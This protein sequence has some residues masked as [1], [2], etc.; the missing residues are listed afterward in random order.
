M[1]DLVD[2]GGGEARDIVTIADA[3]PV[4]P[5][6]RHHGELQLHIGVEGII[7]LEVIAVIERFENTVELLPRVVREVVEDALD[8]ARIEV[9]MMASE[10]LARI[11]DR[12]ALAREV[13][14]QA[15]LLEVRNEQFRQLCRIVDR[16]L[17]R[18]DVGRRVELLDD[19]LDSRMDEGLVEVV[20]ESHRLLL[21]CLAARHFIAQTV[22]A[23]VELLHK[24]TPGEFHVLECLRRVVPR[25]LD[26][27]LLQLVVDELITFQFIIG[28]LK[29]LI[30]VFKF[31][32][33]SFK[34]RLIFI[35]LLAVVEQKD[36]R[37][38][39]AVEVDGKVVRALV[40]LL[41]DEAR[42]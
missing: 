29:L 42:I 38:E 10:V 18:D 7:S 33:P 2:D 24:I 13:I 16:W 31:L 3:V 39:E 8:A 17:C 23:A 12:Q 40:V 26:D 22:A 5:I 9:D 36:Q 21:R 6:L 37:G 20:L 41:A 15:V 35:L 27:A 34:L 1:V 4:R 28:F 30:F 32:S 14:G 11:G 25:R 19:A